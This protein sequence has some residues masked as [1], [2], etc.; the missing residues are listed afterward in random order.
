MLVFSEF[1]AWHEGIEYTVSHDVANTIASYLCNRSESFYR[2]YSK[3][4][5]RAYVASL[6]AIWDMP[7]Y[8]LDEYA[9]VA[10]Q[11][12]C[13]AC[14][15]DIT[16]DRVRMVQINEGYKKFYW[17]IASGARPQF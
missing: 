2:D 13:D 6:A 1:Y 9:R 3:H 10:R 4:Y 12:A 7:Q 14:E 8:D 17:P 11:A 15:I 16:I 5:D